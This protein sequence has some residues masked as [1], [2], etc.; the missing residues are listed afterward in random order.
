MRMFVK[1]GISDMEIPFLALRDC[2]KGL[3]LIIQTIWV[4]GSQLSYSKFFPSA[5]ATIYTTLGKKAIVQRGSIE[6]EQ[7][8]YESSNRRMKQPVDWLS[9][10][11]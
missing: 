8:I 6:H 1:E 10:P 7:I 9:N 5:S 11:H 3:Q 4:H 2:S